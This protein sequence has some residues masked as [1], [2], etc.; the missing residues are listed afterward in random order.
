MKRLLSILAIAVL[1][2]C[3]QA[4]PQAK[5][6]FYFIGDGMGLA[7]VA[8]TEAW[9]A[10]SA[11]V[12]GFEKLSFTEFPVLGMATTFSAGNIITCSSAAGTALATG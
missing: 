10:D 3:Q 11:E 2:G 5:Y 7:Q 8:L 9:L 4:A 1:M 12:I 6:V